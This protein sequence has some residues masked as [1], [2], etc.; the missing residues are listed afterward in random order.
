[1]KTLNPVFVLLLVLFLSSCHRSFN[2]PGA[3][4][5]ADVSDAYFLGASPRESGTSNNL[6]KIVTPGLDSDPIT[7]NFLDEEK[8][9]MREMFSSVY[10]DQIIPL[11]PEYSVLWGDFT[12]TLKEGERH[13]NGLLLHLPTGA[14]FDLAAVYQ[15]NWQNN[16]MG[17]PYHQ[18]DR[19][20]RIYFFGE[21]VKRLVFRDPDHVG[22]EH[23]IDYPIGNE[24]PFFADP[25]GNVYFNLGARVKLFYGGIQETELSLIPIKGFDGNTYGFQNDSSSILKLYRLYA[26]V[27]E[28][29]KEEVMDSNILFEAFYHNLHHYPDS[30]NKRHLIMSNHLFH[31]DGQEFEYLP[32]GIVF[33]ESEL[34]IYPYQLSIDG[35]MTMEILGLEDNYLWLQD[36]GNESR[37]VSVDLDDHSL[38]QASGMAD[39][40]NIAEFDLPSNLEFH[41]IRFNG[42]NAIEFRGYDLAR[43]MWVKGFISMEHGLEY[44]DEESS[45]GSVTLTR[46]R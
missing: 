18:Q 25:D 16:Y 8:D 1:M 46:I 42:V 37:L 38:D 7:V 13:S 21:G 4:A 41:S 33:D 35:L 34:K 43:E 17:S 5:Y 45:L 28:F 22:V 2:K 24:H 6:V 23:Y 29:K 36:Q 40:K 30:V 27:G 20:G 44:F 3:V 26:E 9:M 19:N 39:F 32:V 31:K 12:F 11:S 14:L 10:V 15:P